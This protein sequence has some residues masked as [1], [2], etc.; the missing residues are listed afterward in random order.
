[1]RCCVGGRFVRDKNVG[2]VK[3][4]EIHRCQFKKKLRRGIVGWVERYTPRTYNREKN[5]SDRDTTHRRYIEWNPT[6]FLRCV[7]GVE[8]FV[9]NSV[10]P[11]TFLRGVLSAKL[12]FTVFSMPSNRY[13]VSNVLGVSILV[14]SIP[15]NPTY[16]TKWTQRNP[17]ICNKGVCMKYRRVKIEGRTY[18]FTLVTHNRRPFLCYPDNVELLRQ[19]FRYT[20]Q[21]HPMEIDAFVLL[22]DHL[23]TVWTLSL[24][25]ISE[26]TRPY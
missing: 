12:G 20:V 16:R 5:V 26:P 6:L 23:H 15:F 19:A 25:H 8:M 22:P 2:W 24:I 3:H 18:F 7:W 21:R 4:N 1:M 10:Q 11:N 9:F 13:Y 17:T 14:F